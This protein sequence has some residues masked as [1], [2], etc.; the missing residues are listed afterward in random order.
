MKWLYDRRVLQQNSK[1]VSEKWGRRGG[2]ENGERESE[3]TNEVIIRRDVQSFSQI[4]T[5]KSK[6]EK[7]PFASV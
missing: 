6:I 5:T 1:D 7:R 2:N 4:V 3:A